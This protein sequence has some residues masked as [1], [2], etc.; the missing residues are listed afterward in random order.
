MVV[1][2]KDLEIKKFKA[3]LKCNKYDF[4]AKDLSN[5]ILH[6]SS[7]KHSELRKDLYCSECDFTCETDSHLKMHTSFK[8]PVNFKFSK[9]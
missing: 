7:G 6:M 5:L 1:K 9:T 2:S 8:H 4:V 3:E